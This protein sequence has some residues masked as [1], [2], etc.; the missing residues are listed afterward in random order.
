MH[1]AGDLCAETARKS[2]S[3]AGHDLRE[4][5]GSVKISQLQIEPAENEVCLS[6]SRLLVNS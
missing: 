5:P 2:R 1:A 4:P 3:V 6:V